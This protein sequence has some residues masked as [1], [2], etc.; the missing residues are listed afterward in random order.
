MKV[1]EKYSFNLST[2]SLNEAELHQI[3]KKSI[4]PELQVKA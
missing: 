3:L 1:L 4:K 2:A